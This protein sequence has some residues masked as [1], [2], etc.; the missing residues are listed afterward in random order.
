M[1]DDYEGLWSIWTAIGAAFVGLVVGVREFVGQPRRIRKLEGEVE[2]IKSMLRQ[3]LTSEHNQDEHLEK[4]EE[5]EMDLADVL[6][7]PRDSGFG[8]EETLALAK[9]IIEM[10]TDIRDELR[11]IRL[12]QKRLERIEKGR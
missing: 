11:E 8:T 12:E 3:V 4:I 7:H 5:V 9:Q 1:Q 2:E 6:R 10:L